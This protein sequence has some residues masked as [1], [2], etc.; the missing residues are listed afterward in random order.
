MSNTSGRPRM[1]FTDDEQ[2]LAKSATNAKY[3]RN[4]LEKLNSNQGNQ[5]NQEDFS[6][7]NNLNNNIQQ[8]QLIFNIQVKDYE[9]VTYKIKDGQI[10]DVTHQIIYKTSS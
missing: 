6:Q 8:A 2:K 10:Y 4:K 1:H 7:T 3:Y 9:Y 5:N